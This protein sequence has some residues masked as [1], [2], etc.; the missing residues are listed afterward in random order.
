MSAPLDL[1]ALRGLCEQATPGPWREGSV[2]KEAV[3]CEH[4]CSFGP[5]IERNLLR[6]NKHFPH[7]ADAA[8]IAAARTA[9]PALL[10]EVER[11][12]ELAH[13]MV[14]YVDEFFRDKWGLTHEAV[15]GIEDDKERP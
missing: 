6:L 11:L 15:D 5:G 10:D 3:F 2:E 8:F 13:E 7:E 1:A 4:G 9:L 14:G 12:R